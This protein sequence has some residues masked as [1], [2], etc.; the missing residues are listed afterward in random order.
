MVTTAMMTAEQDTLDGAAV[1]P[2]F[3]IAVRDLWPWDAR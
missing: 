1:L 2:G 3:V